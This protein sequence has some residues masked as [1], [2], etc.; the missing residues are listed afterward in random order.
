MR[1]NICGRDGLAPLALTDVELA[2]V[3]QAMRHYKSTELP[4]RLLATIYALT[5]DEIDEAES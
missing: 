1:L 2:G 5:P 3:A 4:A